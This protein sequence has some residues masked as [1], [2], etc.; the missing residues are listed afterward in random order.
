MRYLFYF[1]SLSIFVLLGALLGAPSTNAQSVYDETLQYSP[2]PYRIYDSNNQPA[3]ALQSTFEV[4]Q[5]IGG[6]GNNSTANGFCGNNTINAQF[7][8]VIEH[9]RL[10]D[11]DYVIQSDTRLSGV[12]NRSIIIRINMENNRTPIYTWTENQVV[13]TYQVGQ[14]YEYTLIYRNDTQ[15]VIACGIPAENSNQLIY[16]QKPVLGFTSSTIIET[17]MPA[18]YPPGYEGTIIAPVDP[19]IPP[20]I[21]VDYWV[22][23]SYTNTTSILRAQYLNKQTDPTSDLPDPISIYW[24]LFVDAPIVTE[25]GSVVCESNRLVNVP[26]DTF[27]VCPDFTPDATKQYYLYAQINPD[28]NPELD[29]RLDYNITF[30]VNVFKIDFSKSS[31]G[32]TENCEPGAI[33]QFM[34]KNCIAPETIDFSQCFTEGFP[35]ID[36]FEC[37]DNFALIFQFLTF[38]GIRFPEWS[39]DPQCKSLNTMD[40][41]LNLPNGYTACPL[42]PSTVRMIVTPFIA[43]L[44]GIVTLG[45]IQRHNQ[46]GGY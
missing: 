42:F 21:D 17:N 4:G 40:D 34:N 28:K 45:F 31:T 15:Q 27:Q 2:T 33:L 9:I 41:W 14:V 23:Y 30:K 11:R 19:P 35:F 16:G 18:T 38:G 12:N 8:D 7:P 10:S 39:H 5:I 29:D 20:A 13:A 46:S 44:L 36:P 6:I 26:F 25:G 32:T 43:F 24:R 37:A 1:L 22:N 3:L